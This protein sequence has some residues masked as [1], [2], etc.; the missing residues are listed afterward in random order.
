ARHPRRP[1][2]TAFSSSKEFAMFRRPCALLVLVYTIALPA[3]AAAQAD[4]LATDL[5]V[6]R[7]ANL[8]TDGA[9]LISFFKKRTLAEDTRKKIA[10][11]I[12]QLGD[13]EYSVREKATTDLVDIGSAARPMLTQALRNRDLEVRRRA[14][15]ALEKRGPASSE[16]HLLL[17][18][19]RVLAQRKPAG[20]A[21]VL[22]NFLPNIEEPETAEEV[23]RTVAR[24]AM[25]KDGKPEKAVLL[26]L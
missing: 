8:N 26:A 25:G 19:A 10:K 14:G 9:G 22:L 23:A 1:T 18:A 21:E 12:G 15:W 2:L 24:V 17:A 6:L 11:L 3:T 7:A 5:A 20:A 4:S 13:D 16:A